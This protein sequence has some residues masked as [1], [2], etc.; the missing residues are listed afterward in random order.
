MR[1]RTGIGIL[2]AV[3]WIAA[4]GTASGQLFSS[5]STGADGAFNP[6][7][8]VTVTL[9][10][11]GVLNYTTVTIP[12]GVTVK[13]SKNA[14]NTPVT[15]LATGDVTI[16]GTIDLNGVSGVFGNG[17]TPSI[18]GAGGPGG[19]DGG[20]GGL[21]PNVA[22]TDGKGPGGGTSRAGGTYGAPAGFVT[23]TPLFGGSG[24]G[25]G[26]GT[27]SSGGGGGGAIVI[28][29][30]T[31]ISILNGV[32]RAIGGE[33]RGQDVFCATCSGGGS[34]GAIRLV[35]PEI[36]GSGTVSAAG[37]PAGAG[38]SGPGGEPGRI[39]LEAFT[40]NLTGSVTPPP[41]SVLAPGPVSGSGVPA[42]V[43]L[44]MLTIAS[45]GGVAAPA[46][47]GGAYT[48]GDVVLPPGTTNP[49]PV[50]IAA[51]YTPRDATTAITLK[52]I[53]QTSSPATTT[54]AISGSS[55]GGTFTSSTVSRNVTFPTG[56]V[57]VLQAWASMTL[58][59]QI[60]SLMPLIDG[61][62]V[63]RMQVMAEQGQPS[64]LSLVTRTGKTVRVDQLSREDQL[65]VARAWGAMKA[66]SG[67]M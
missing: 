43:S 8:S 28:A 17:I 67:E 53:T 21:S 66:T 48:A 14:A 23:L 60:A 65:R 24:G 64:T 42:L 61:E 20:N 16:S 33:S 26:A 5:G 15:M 11:D 50:V 40:L 34:G 46:V 9:P 59:G 7:A 2:C 49:V 41:S 38:F 58:T 30:S 36:S 51:A 47:P 12:A 39:R 55:L 37:G 6:T 54:F 10:A 18:G 25:G 56:Q 31:R 19:F 29:S 45:V 13:F 27:G 62:P 57:S 1:T 52:L 4:V 32:I 63:E 22:F 3:G 35:A 44:P